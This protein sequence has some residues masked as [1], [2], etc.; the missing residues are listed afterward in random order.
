MSDEDSEAAYVEMEKRLVASH[1]KLVRDA[2]PASGLLFPRSD[3]AHA[4]KPWN[5][6]HRDYS[7]PYWMRWVG[8]SLQ[9][10]HSE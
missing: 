6:R 8:A 4:S 1:I 9:A 2:Y 3:A 5:Q 7:Y 10:I